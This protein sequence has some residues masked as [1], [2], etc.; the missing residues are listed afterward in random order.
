MTVPNEPIPFFDSPYAERIAVGVRRLRSDTIAARLEVRRL[1]PPLILTSDLV[2]LQDFGSAEVVAM[3]ASREVLG[4]L[5]KAVERFQRRACRVWRS[6]TIPF[7]GPR[8]R[9][10]PADN[11]EPFETAMTSLCEDFRRQAHQPPLK[12]ITVTFGLRDLSGVLLGP[13]NSPEIYVGSFGVRWDYP[14]SEP[15]PRLKSHYPQVY[16]EEQERL[17]ERFRQAAEE[18]D[19]ALLGEVVRLANA[20][21]ELLKDQSGAAARR[22]RSWQRLAEGFL[23]LKRLNVARDGAVDLVLAEAHKI[24]RKLGTRPPKSGGLAA[25]RV[26]ATIR[27]LQSELYEIRAT[28]TYP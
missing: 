6:M 2:K 25:R 21:L 3:P 9:L 5:V 23:R 7:P 12:S 11:I 22:A 18:A 13:A 20:A 26:A 19:A 24:L 27:W 8:V 16:R 14:S 1:K 10:L 28:G 4:S 17:S 15:D